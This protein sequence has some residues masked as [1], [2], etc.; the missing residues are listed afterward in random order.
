MAVVASEQFFLLWLPWLFLINLYDG[1]QQKSLQGFSF[2][3]T[4]CDANIG[5]KNK[6]TKQSY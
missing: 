2:I 3:Y 1:K 5:K 6:I 4:L